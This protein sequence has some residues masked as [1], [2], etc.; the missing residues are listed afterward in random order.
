MASE[1]DTWPGRRTPK[2][3]FDQYS[4]Q[5]DKCRSNIRALT[6]K[7]RKLSYS[8]RHN[9]TATQ[10]DMAL[11]RVTA[12][13]VFTSEDPNQHPVLRRTAEAR[14][15]EMT[16]C[17]QILDRLKEVVDWNQVHDVAPFA[18]LENNL[19]KARGCISELALGLIALGDIDPKEAKRPLNTPEEE[20]NWEYF[21][22]YMNQGYGVLDALDL[23]LKAQDRRRPNQGQKAY[24]TEERRLRGAESPPRP[25]KRRASPPFPPPKQPRS[26]P[27]IVPSPDDEKVY[28]GG[29]Q[30]DHGEF[31]PD[32]ASPGG[33]S[34][35]PDTPPT[36]S[37]GIHPNSPFS[38]KTPKTPKYAHTKARRSPA[39]SPT[40]PRK[41]WWNVFSSPK[42]SKS[43]PKSTRSPNTFHSPKSPHY[44]SPPPPPPRRR[45]SS[46]RVPLPTF[47]PTGNG[48]PYNVEERVPGGHR[49]PAPVANFT[50]AGNGR[51][52]NVEERVPGGH[53]GPTPGG[54]Y[55]PGGA[56]RYYNVEERV[57]GG[58]HFPAPG[59]NFSPAGNGRPY[60]VE[61]RV[62][63]GHHGLAPG[64]NYIPGGAG[65]HYKV[66][67]WAPGKHR[68]PQTGAKHHDVEIRTVYGRHQF[69]RKRR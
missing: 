63:G 67:E 61:E 59:G 19:P 45:S 27:P 4:H 37:P 62:P 55:I 33:F 5:Y 53:R 32:P 13:A 16:Q 14:L 40:S 58:Q 49:G 18:F 56:G 9:L 50:P 64:A 3:S 65:R 10:P 30:P 54:N 48:R 17:K 60:N 25:N 43:S 12:R 57:P 66:E 52:Y 2:S 6:T 38:P 20:E 28:R 69:A 34:Y 35:R 46:P 51:P 22:H 8:N 41:H 7:Y 11:V 42:S 44:Y 47:T 15:G 29:K 31:V 39:L 26:P 68:S 1:W 24:K 36:A 21:Y 23:A